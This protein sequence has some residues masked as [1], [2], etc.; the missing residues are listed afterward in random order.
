MEYGVQVPANNNN[1]PQFHP[2]GPANRSLACAAKAIKLIDLILAPWPTWLSLIMFALTS[3]YNIVRST[4]NL[5][6]CQNPTVERTCKSR[7]Q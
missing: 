1:G 4:E 3:T 6:L 5:F 7:S 2:S